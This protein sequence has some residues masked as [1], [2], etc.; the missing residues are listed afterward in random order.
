[1][2]RCL[3]LLASLLATAPLIAQ[4]PAAPPSAPGA[5]QVPDYLGFYA[6]N[7]PGFAWTEGS[8]V[9][10]QYQRITGVLNVDHSSKPV[11]LSEGRDPLPLTLDQTSRLLLAVD[12]AKAFD[13]VGLEGSA[14]GA[15]GTVRKFFVV[16][17]A[18][19]GDRQINLA[20]NLTSSSKAAQG[21]APGGMGAGGPPGGR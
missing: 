19:V 17:L 5:S 15:D 1:M 16:F 3:L 2:P 8:S 21:Q 13:L 6:L 14:R 20:P 12:G 4:S 7:I 10:A 11:F 18:M 9:T